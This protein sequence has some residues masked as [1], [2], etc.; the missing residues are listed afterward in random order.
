MFNSSIVYLLFLLFVTLNVM[1]LLYYVTERMDVRFGRL[2]SLCLMVGAGGSWSFGLMSMF[3]VAG[4]VSANMLEEVYLLWACGYEH[5]GIYLEPESCFFVDIVPNE[6]GAFTLKRSGGCYE[7]VSRITGG[8]THLLDDKLMLSHLD[9]YD[10]FDIK[11]ERTSLSVLTGGEYTKW[12][13]S[14]FFSNKR[15]LA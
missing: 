7:I 2:G 3:R 1:G 11:L 4:N 10:N 9:L 8:S 15:K 14:P 5:M 6:R 13:N 12:I